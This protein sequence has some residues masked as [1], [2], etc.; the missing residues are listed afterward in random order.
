MPR[1]LDC[2]LTDDLVGSAVPGDEVTVVGTVELARS[3]PGSGFGS[4]VGGPVDCYLLANHVTGEQK[5]A[6]SVSPLGPDLGRGDYYAIEA[7]HDEPQ[8]FRL[9]VNSLCP[10]IYGHEVRR[11]VR[12]IT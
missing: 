1:I 11:L 6:A 5:N 4:A 8:L 12:A 7:I 9:L 2:E 10:A 3:E